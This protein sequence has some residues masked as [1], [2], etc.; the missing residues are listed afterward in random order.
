METV[1]TTLAASPRNL[2][3]P[4]SPCLAV[5]W[6]DWYAYHIA[7]FRALALHPALHNR[8]VG[9]ELVGR[10]GVHEGLVFRDLQRE[11]L[12]ITTLAREQSW[13]DVGQ[14][15][16]AGLMWAHLNELG[17]DVVLVPGYYTLPA[18]ASVVWAKL[19]GKRAVLMTESTRR[20]HLRR[21]I[22]EGLKRTLLRRFFDC[23]IAGGERQV[24]YLKE[25][26]FDS[27]SIGRLYDV[28]DNEYFRQQSESF[29]LDG[30]PSGTLPEKYFLFVGRLAEEKNV[31]GLIRAFAAYRDRG[32]DWS[33]I[34]VGDGPTA[35]ALRNQ[36]EQLNLTGSVHFAG[37]K[38]ASELGFY[39]AHAGCFILPSWREPWGLVVN[40]AMA[41]KLPVILSD[42]CGC[43]DDLLEEGRNGYRFDPATEEALPRLMSHV[44]R[45][46]KGQRRQMGERS[47]GIIARYSPELWAE[48][49][50]RIAGIRNT[51]NHCAR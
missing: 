24:S 48:E 41:A 42:C 27:P 22:V 36:T 45:L 49:V 40:E 12:P 20:D 26:G 10:G 5:I 50:V 28:V 23:A 51:T 3:R 1:G 7:R 39:Y 47:A 32:G 18:V 34:V 16:L 11:E 6:I 4:A 17:P 44:S 25:L 38:R 46:S 37:L 35:G 2:A 43:S 33:L 29:R 9:I 8:V 14:R 13:R 15:R 21:P 19:H 31:D 30:A